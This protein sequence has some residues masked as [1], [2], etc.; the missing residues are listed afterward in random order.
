MANNKLLF[1]FTISSEDIRKADRKGSRDAGLEIGL[2]VPHAVHKT[3]KTYNKK[4]KSW[5]KFQINL[6]Y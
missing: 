3:K 6:T 4:D 2:V 5:K 1:K